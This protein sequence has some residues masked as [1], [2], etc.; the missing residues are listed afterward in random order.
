MYVCIECGSRAK[1]LFLRNSSAQQVSRCPSCN[2][3]M[4]RY[5]ELNGLIKLID[6]LLLKRR[7][8]RHYLFNSKRDFTKD[9]LIMLAVRMFTEPIL[10][11]HEALGLLLSEGPG[12]G[13][14]IAEMATICRDVLESLMETSLLLVLVFS[15]F[16]RH[17][18]FVRLSSALLLSSFYYLFMF[19]MT[20][21]RYQCEEYLLVIEFLCVACN[22]IVISE[23]CLVRNEVALGC[24]YGCK[25]AAGLVCKRILGTI[26]LNLFLSGCS[27]IPKYSPA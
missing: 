20:M 23:I 1:H 11:H 4:D 22:S 5:F 14:S 18:G 16:H 19:I 25:F 17:A 7:I 9:V 27:T 13:V 15:M 6:L 10:Q 24:I 26:R 2:R 8:F 3:K 21:W 12:E